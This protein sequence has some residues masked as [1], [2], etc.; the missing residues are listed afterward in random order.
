MSDENIH[1]LSP[2]IDVG[3]NLTH[4]RFDADRDDVILRAQA[5]GVQAMVVTGINAAES[6]LAEQLTRQWPGY[7]FATAGCHPHDADTWNASTKEAIQGL[8]KRPGVVA[9]G[10]CG[11]DY[12]R[13]FS[14]RAR[15]R[16]AFVAQLELAAETGRPVFAHLREATAD[17]IAIVR[18]HAASLSAMCVHCFTDGPETLERLLPLGCYFGVTGW[19]CD[20]RRNEPLLA[21]LPMIP[22]DRLLLE[23][24]APFLLPR[25]LPH[26]PAG[27]RNEPAFLPHI[28]RAVARH[29]DLDAV[30]LAQYTSCNAQRFFRLLAVDDS[31]EQGYT[32][33]T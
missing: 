20:E 22:V 8:L 12:Y 5:A 16:A 1:P 15:Q 25:D 2:L 18:E 31:R 32:H 27:G 21:A 14:D 9:V 24:D 6:Q 11:L 4:R 10:E 23:T 33:E 13:D 26:R 3:V 7:L 29:L 19:L 17:F 28:C 30:Q